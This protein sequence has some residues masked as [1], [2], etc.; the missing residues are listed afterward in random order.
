[1]LSSLLT[2]VLICGF[3]CFGFSEFSFNETSTSSSRIFAY[4]NDDL[5]DERL[6]LK[7]IVTQVEVG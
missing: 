2:T 4:V 7:L 3:F 6:E 1:M 5:S